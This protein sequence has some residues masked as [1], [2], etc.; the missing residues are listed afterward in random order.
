MLS[1]TEY[2]NISKAYANIYEST[3]KTCDN[4]C[5]S[6]EGNE[7]NENFA[8]ARQNFTDKDISSG[9][10]E[11]AK[12]AL[13]YF[14]TVRNAPMK[15]GASPTEEELDALF[16]EELNRIEETI[17]GKSGEAELYA[18]QLQSYRTR[19]RKSIGKIDEM[20]IIAAMRQGEANSGIKSPWNSKYAEWDPKFRH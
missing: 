1:T 16:E 2:L 13:A 8:E 7:T 10:L 14:M 5:C 18:G 11:T 17:A 15:I 4:G 3:K 9:D 12:N 20:P 6:N 19:G